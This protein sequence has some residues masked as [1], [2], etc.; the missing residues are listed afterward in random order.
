M[1]IIVLRN[2]GKSYK[3]TISV[4]TLLTS[5]NQSTIKHSGGSS[6]TSHGHMQQMS[7]TLQPRVPVAILQFIWFPLAIFNP[8]QRAYQ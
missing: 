7:E 6:P 3:I 2:P 1:V 4:D 8:T 5:K